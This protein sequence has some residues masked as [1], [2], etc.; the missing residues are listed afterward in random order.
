MGGGQTEKQITLIED[1]KP[2]AIMVTPSYMLN[3][4]EAYR[5]AGLDPRATS[6]QVGIFGAEPW[7]NSM[8][9]EIEQSFDL[10][11]DRTVGVDPNL[12]YTFRLDFDK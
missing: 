10:D 12:Q 5:A 1:F 6:L 3:I 11:L 8:R 2:K 4:L 7:T 9:E